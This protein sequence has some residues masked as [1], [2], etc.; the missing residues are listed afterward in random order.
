M[1]ARDDRAWGA[2]VAAHPDGLIY[3]RPEWLHLLQ[4]EYGGR[5]TCLV[6]RDA[7]GEIQGV[8]PLAWTKGLPFVS[9]AH[10]GRRLSS[11]PRTPVAGP[12][13]TDDRACGALI[14]A[15]L[16]LVGDT[17]GASLEIKL[18]HTVAA[19]AG[20]AP[21]PW[22][23]AYV[24]DLPSRPEDLRF[25]SSRNHARIRWSIGKAERCG[26]VVRDA[27]SAA[28]VR[29]W[30]RLY[31]DTMRA[32][33]L[34]P[35]PIRLFEGM[36]ELLRP[37]GLMRLSL[38]L[39]Q[40]RLLAGSIYLM[41]GQTVFY[42]FNGCHRTELALRPN[43]VLQW[44]AIVDACR[45]GYRHY[46]LGEVSRGNEGLAEFKAKWGARERQLQRCYH[47]RPAGQQPD[48]GPERFKAIEKIW[49]RLPLPLTAGIGDRVY[50]Y[51]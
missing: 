38:A 12:L 23:S 30:Y 24:L 2:F 14:E 15:A 42:A 45:A 10:T 8:L 7:T 21:V 16:Q 17:P 22:R 46:D 19:T 13:A 36:W 31:L 35:R 6:C 26:V 33:A 41:S 20:L 29:S 9:G 40:G 28:E 50:R 4:G 44:H 51:M 34:P 11:L 32:H 5:V 18:S 27:D 39:Q 25:G 37:R 1:E 3:H 49:R 43:D 48:G 47:P